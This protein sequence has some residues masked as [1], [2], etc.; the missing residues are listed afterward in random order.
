MNIS[1]GF[2]AVC[3][4]FWRLEALSVFVVIAVLDKVENFQFVK[5]T[6]RATKI[7][8]IRTGKFIL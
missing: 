1:A 8:F 2:S 6:I 3:T 7:L 5:M 4:C